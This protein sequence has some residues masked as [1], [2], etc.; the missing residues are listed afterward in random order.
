VLLSQFHY[1]E[2]FAGVGGR[3]L[4]ALLAL[5]LAALIAL[6]WSARAHGRGASPSLS[7]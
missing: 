1:V 6:G 5:Y 2:P 7:R 3:Q 4:I